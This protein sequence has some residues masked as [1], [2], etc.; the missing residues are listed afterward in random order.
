MSS[1]N[2]SDGS[3]VDNSFQTDAARIYISQLTDIDANFGIDPG[4]TG[5]MKERSGI[6]IKA[7]GVRVIGREGIKLITG[8][9]RGLMKRTPLPAIYFQPHD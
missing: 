8:V 1:T 5:Y 7:D 6:G 9:C 2:A 4:K 3:N